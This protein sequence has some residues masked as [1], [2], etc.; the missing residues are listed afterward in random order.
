MLFEPVWTRFIV[1]LLSCLKRVNYLYKD[2]TIVRENIPLNLQSFVDSNEG[3]KS[4]TSYLLSHLDEPIEIKLTILYEEGVDDNLEMAENPL[5]IFGVASN[6]TT[7][8]SNFPDVDSKESII[9]IASVEGQKPMSVLNDDYCEELANPH[10][11]PN[12]TFGY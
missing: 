3:G 8:I 11:L 5:D 1:D 7:L 2:T 10:L 6:E 12:G 9:S 4:L